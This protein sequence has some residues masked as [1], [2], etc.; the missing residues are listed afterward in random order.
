MDEPSPKIDSAH[1]PAPKSLSKDPTSVI[2]FPPEGNCS[3]GAISMVDVHLQEVMAHI[4][5]KLIHSLEKQLNHCEE[6]RLANNL[7][8]YALL[9]T[10]Y[11]E[12]D[13][14]EAT[15][16]AMTSFSSKANKKNVKRG[17]AGRIHKW[18][19]DLCMQV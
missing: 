12:I 17:L 19:G 5:V 8:V 1:R 4:S 16:A 14:A 15:A 3:E 2:V 18:M 7:P 10:H 11:D 9:S 6:A 13:D